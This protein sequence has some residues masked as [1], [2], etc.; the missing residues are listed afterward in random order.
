MEFRGFRISRSKTK[1]LH[2]C[3]SGREDERGAVTIEGTQIPKVE[4]FKYLGS[5]IHHEGDIDEDISQAGQNGRTSGVLCDKRML[6][7]LKGK[8]Y[9]T[10]VRPAMLY[11]LECWPI[12]KTQVQSLMVAEMG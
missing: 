6:E 1:Y 9:R 11:G 8:V 5:I 10:A 2:C 12:K 7:G 4:K 3:F